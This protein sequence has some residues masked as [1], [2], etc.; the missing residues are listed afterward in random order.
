VD[1]SIKGG[2]FLVQG[3][4]Q[5]RLCY[6]EF[7]SML[8]SSYV[9]FFFTFPI[10]LPSGNILKFRNVKSLVLLNMALVLL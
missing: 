5:E 10:Q 2:E 8:V 3:S 1:S 4:S 9:F 6:L 7:V